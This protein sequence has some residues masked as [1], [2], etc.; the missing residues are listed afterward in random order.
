VIFIEQYRHPLGVKVIELP[1]GLVGDDP[2]AGGEEW[3]AAAKRELLEETGYA[4]DNWKLLIEGPSSP[5]LTTERYSMYLAAPARQVGE[6]GGDESE[7]ITIH[8]VP[9]DK[10]EVWLEEKR[11]AGLLVDPKIYAG[12][13]FA[14]KPIRDWGWHDLMI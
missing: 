8:V 5:G 1:A 14:W 6:G 7:D 4:S 12:L 10:T 13:Y 11:K 3:L 9:L 2:G